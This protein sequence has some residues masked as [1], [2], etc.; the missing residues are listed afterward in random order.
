CH[1]NTTGRFSSGCRSL[2]AMSRNSR[3]SP[4]L[5]IT[6]GPGRSSGHSPS[7]AGSG[8]GSMAP[9]GGSLRQSNAPTGGRSSA[10][11][12]WK[13]GTEPSSSS[14]AEPLPI[15]V[16]S[17]TWPV[18]PSTVSPAVP[19]ADDDDDVSP[20]V[21]PTSSTTHA[22]PSRNNDTGRE[23][24]VRVTPSTIVSRYHHGCCG[25]YEIVVSYVGL[26]SGPWGWPLGLLM[27]GIPGR[28]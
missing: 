3:R 6:L 13:S 28:T 1:K 12:S 14:E 11:G 21:M 23:S 5:S 22:V 9:A 26:G 10:A 18:M 17:E 4:E 20:G 15:V 25:G 27:G 24:H 7:Y 19:S 2:G 16:S 8:G